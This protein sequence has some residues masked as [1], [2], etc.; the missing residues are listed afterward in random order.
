[1]AAPPPRRISTSLAPRWATPSPVPLSLNSTLDITNAY[2][3]LTAQRQ[4]HQRDEHEHHR[5][6]R[7]N[8]TISSAIA[9]GTGSL[10]LSGSGRLVLTGNNSLTGGINLNSGICRPSTNA[11]ALGGSGNALNL[12]G[13]MCAHG[14]H[15]HCLDRPNNTTVSGN[16]IIFLDRGTTAGAGVTSTMGTLS[17]GSQTLDVLG[18]GAVTHQRHCRLDLRPHHLRAIPPSTSRTEPTAATSC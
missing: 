1:M 6:R 10:T 4:R 11:N 3:P 7:G 9:T 5:G 17:M 13:G 15:G 2:A 18:G 12:A 14:R 8:T 16:S